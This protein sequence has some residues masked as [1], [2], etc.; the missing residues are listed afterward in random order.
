MATPTELLP[1]GLDSWFSRSDKDGDGQVSMAEYSTKWDAEVT[2]KFQSL[3]TNGDG[4][5]SANEALRGG[6]SSRR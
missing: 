5:I 3:D 1:A 6:S 4:F 2:K